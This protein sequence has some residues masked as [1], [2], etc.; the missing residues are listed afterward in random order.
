MDNVQNQGNAIMKALKNPSPHGRGWPSP[1]YR[2]RAD[3]EYA[4]KYGTTIR[5]SALTLPAKQ[6]SYCE[7]GL[8]P[9]PG[10]EGI[11]QRAL[12]TC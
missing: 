4:L 5:S 6:V 8:L 11:V 3:E 1:R 12:M 10:G 7:A 2:V 9:L